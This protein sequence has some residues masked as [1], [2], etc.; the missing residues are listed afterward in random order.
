MAQ[1]IE[2]SLV[3]RVQAMWQ[4]FQFFP[5]LCLFI[6]VSVSVSVSLSVFISLL[7]LP[8]PLSVFFCVT[9]H[10]N[11]LILIRCDLKQVISTFGIPF[12]CLVSEGVGQ[13]VC[14]GTNPRIHPAAPA[15]S[16]GPLASPHT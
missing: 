9:Q 1:V 11:K 5:S 3:Q 15:L 6:S 4:E 10:V 8:L 7:S 14:P 13:V 2:N 12:S 16:G